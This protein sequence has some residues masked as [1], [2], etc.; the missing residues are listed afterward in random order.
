MTPIPIAKHYALAY[1][2]D[3]G[4]NRSLEYGDLTIWRTRL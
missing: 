3:V 2:F 1:T 4:I